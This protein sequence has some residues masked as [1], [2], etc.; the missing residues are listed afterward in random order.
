MKFADLFVPKWQ[1]SNPEVRKK[2]VMKITDVSLLNQIAEKD[3]DSSVRETA[4]GRL[5]SIS[6]SA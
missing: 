5:S 2:A 1:N 4:G 3:E 6:E